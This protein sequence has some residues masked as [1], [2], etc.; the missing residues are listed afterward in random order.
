MTKFWPSAPNDAAKHSSPLLGRAESQRR[1]AF[2]LIGHV[3]GRARHEHQRAI[4]ILGQ[5]GAVELG[6]LA[7]SRLIPFTQR[8]V[9]KG[10]P[11]SAARPLY[12]ACKREIS[13]S[14]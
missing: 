13:T 11:S 12:S 9:S 10:A 8:A 5:I 3:P 7:Q 14:S 2:L 1:I 6:K 4:A